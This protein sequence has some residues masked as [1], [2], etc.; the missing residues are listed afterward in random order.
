VLP[1]DPAELLDA[2]I[3]R[4]GLAD[5]GPP[6]FREGLEGVGDRGPDPGRAWAVRSIFSQ[7]DEIS[8]VLRSRIAFFG[9]ECG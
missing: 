2:A 5:F 4:T 9:Q 6:S 8:V 7:N 3:G 1:A